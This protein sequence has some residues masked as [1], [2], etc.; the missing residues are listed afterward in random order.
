M[1]C[2]K[3]SSYVDLQT[4]FLNCTTEKSDNTVRNEKKL[5]VDRFLMHGPSCLK[6]QNGLG[7]FCIIHLYSQRS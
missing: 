5:A 4:V 2:E 1:S 3:F 6:G 7:E